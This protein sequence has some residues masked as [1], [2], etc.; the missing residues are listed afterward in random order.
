MFIYAYVIVSSQVDQALIKAIQD[1]DKLMESLVASSSN[2]KD[3]ADEDAIFCSSLAPK[4][5]RMPVHD[6]SQVQMDLLQVFVNY[7]ARAQ[8]DTRPPVSTG[9]PPAMEYT[10]LLNSTQTGYHHH[11]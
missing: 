7:E 10:E 5:R 8:P 2:T 11:Y 1:G 3:C 4:F 6:K 9:L